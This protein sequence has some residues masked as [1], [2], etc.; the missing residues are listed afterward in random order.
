M[1]LVA[2]R[3]VLSFLRS[4]RRNPQKEELLFDLDAIEPV[5]LGSDPE[6]IAASREQLNLLLERF[7]EGLSPLGWLMFDLLYI[8][9]LSQAEVQAATGLS[10]DAVY[11]WRSRLRFKAQQLLAKMSESGV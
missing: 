6:K 2:E 1:G 7:R 9:D 3:Q 5:F 8:Q 10:D 4:G 11:A